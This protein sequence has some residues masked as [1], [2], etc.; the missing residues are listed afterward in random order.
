MAGDLHEIFFSIL[1]RRSRIQLH[2]NFSARLYPLEHDASWG[3]ML[4]AFV[5]HFPPFSKLAHRGTGFAGRGSHYSGR[6]LCGDS[7]QSHFGLEC[8]GLLRLPFEFVGTNLPAFQ[9]LLVFAVPA[10]F[11]GAS[12]S[13]KAVFGAT[14]LHTNQHA[15]IKTPSVS[16][17]LTKLRGNGGRFVLQSV[18]LLY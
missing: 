17:Q 13:A 9:F 11:L 6:A 15:I 5:P 1:H 7:C 10:R 8:L 16:S 2:R 3:A 12:V 18:I 4:D 14:R